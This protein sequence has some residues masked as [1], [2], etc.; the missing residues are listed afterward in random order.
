MKSNRSDPDNLERAAEALGHSRNHVGEQAAHEPVGGLG[1]LVVSLAVHQGAAI[2]ELDP[3]ER[4]DSGT[5]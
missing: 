4:G 5:K 1:P 2:P 3:G